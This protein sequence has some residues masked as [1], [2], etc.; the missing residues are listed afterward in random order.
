MQSAKSQ[1]RQRVQIH[2]GP[3]HLRHA[4]PVPDR[5]TAIS[6]KSIESIRNFP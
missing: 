4:M 5:A 1:T 6:Q 2:C 3:P